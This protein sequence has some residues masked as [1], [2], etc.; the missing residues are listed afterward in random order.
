MMRNANPHL[1]WCDVTNRGYGALKFTRSACEAEWVAFANV[2]TPE[3]EAPVITRC[4]ATPSAQS[5]P[6]AWST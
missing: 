5:G 3:V 1:A 4:A 6:G 2:R